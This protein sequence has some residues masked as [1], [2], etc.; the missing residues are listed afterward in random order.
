M[1]YTLMYPLYFQANPDIR[2]YIS[3]FKST[4]LHYYYFQGILQLNSLA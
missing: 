4:L 3:N 2:G 1:I